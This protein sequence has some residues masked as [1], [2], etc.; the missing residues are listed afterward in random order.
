M[1]FVDKNILKNLGH[2]ISFDDF[3]IRILS[4]Y[5]TEMKVLFCFRFIRIF[6]VSAQKNWNKRCFFFKLRNEP[7]SMRFIAQLFV[8]IEKRRMTRRL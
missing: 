4:W 5:K 8:N 1:K 7:N 2:G 6:H 3:C